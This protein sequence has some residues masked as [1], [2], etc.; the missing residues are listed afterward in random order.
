ME[1]QTHFSFFSLFILYFL[2]IFCGSMITKIHS[3]HYLCSLH[4]CLLNNEEDISAVIKT[5]CLASFFIWVTPHISFQN[6]KFHFLLPTSSSTFFTQSFHK[7][8][9]PYDMFFVL[10]LI[11]WWVGFPYINNSK[12][13]FLFFFK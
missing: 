11:K 4:I 9:F 5:W 3:L 7:G 10:S 6:I 1:S 13:H 12:F 2:K 8:G